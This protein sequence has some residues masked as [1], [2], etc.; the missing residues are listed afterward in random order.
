MKF[1]KW[2]IGSPAQA[3]VARLQNAGYQVQKGAAAGPAASD[4]EHE[5]PLP[6]LQVHPGQGLKAPAAGTK[7][8][9]ALLSL[10]YF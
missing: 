3:D 1:E 5:L 9:S 4:K 6:Y 10:I 2:N 7:P 8:P